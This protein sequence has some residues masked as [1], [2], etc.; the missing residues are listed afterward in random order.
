MASVVGEDLLQRA[1][2]CFELHE[3]VAWAQVGKLVGALGPL[4][5]GRSNPRWS[6]ILGM[7]GERSAKERSRRSPRGVLCLH[8]D[9]LVG[10]EGLS[11]P[12]AEVL[13]HLGHPAGLFGGLENGQHKGGV[14]VTN[15]S[16][17]APLDSVK[18][19]H[20][21]G[22]ADLCGLR[23]EEQPL[24]RV[25]LHLARCRVQSVDTPG[26][27]NGLCVGRVPRESAPAWTGGLAGWP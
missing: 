1:G 18:V 15:A 5:L 7:S 27:V 11:C 17:S 25:D 20:A 9:A 3:A 4:S 16:S 26:D 22:D 13:L 6:C 21:P 2:L 19:G 14:P 8:G 24:D 10:T 12:L 23:P